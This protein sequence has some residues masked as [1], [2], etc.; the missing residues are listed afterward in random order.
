MVRLTGQEI[1][2]IEK[3]LYFTEPKRRGHTAIGWSHREAPG[4]SGGRGNVSKR[5]YCDFCRKELVRQ[6]EQG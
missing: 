3:I 1:T 6:G 5:L 2:A 4:R